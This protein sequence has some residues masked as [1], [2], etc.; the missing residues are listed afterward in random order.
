MV[1][2]EELVHASQSDTLETKPYLLRL[3]F[4]TTIL[5]THTFHMSLT[6]MKEGKRG[7][8]RE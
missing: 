3:P 1:V 4:N 7:G 5:L 6:A 8:R 2:A